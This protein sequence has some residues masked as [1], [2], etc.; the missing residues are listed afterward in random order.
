MCHGC[1]AHVLVF[2][3]IDAD[4]GVIVC[5]LVTMWR[6]LSFRLLS[7]RTRSV[8]LAPSLPPIQLFPPPSLVSLCDVEGKMAI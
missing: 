4:V 5:A 2:A 1:K 3:A 6:S 8:F 7:L